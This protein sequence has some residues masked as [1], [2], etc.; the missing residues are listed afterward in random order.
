MSYPARPRIHPSAVISSDAELADDVEV[1]AYAVIDGKIRLGQG[2]VIRPG[3]FLFGDIIM[4]QG[5]V[6]FTG[7]VLGEQPQHLKYKGEP[8]S[9]EI[10][11]FNTF[12]E[13]V[14]VHRGTT[15]SMRTVIGSHNFLMA[16]CHI[17]HD[18]VVGDRCIFTNGSLVAGH[19]TIENNVIVS[20]NSCLSQF[21]RV[22]RLAFLSGVSASTKDIP[23][24]MTYQGID[25]A[26]GVNLV[27]LKRAGMSNSQIDAI[28]Q[29]FRMLYRDGL[30]LPAA[31]VKIEHEM[32]HIDVIQELLQFLRGSSRGI[33]LMRSRFREDAA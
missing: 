7:A 11:D 13:H 5:N 18:C 12:R 16:G 2:C 32:G 1:G 3:A 21:C 20:G 28:R 9:L 25:N 26:S 14:T 22:G 4:G 10:G 30:V 24:F 31:M 17:A 29:V 27:G 6:V 8:T 15:H 23:P 33:S 19:C